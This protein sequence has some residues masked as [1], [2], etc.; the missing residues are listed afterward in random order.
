MF[1]VDDY[2]GLLDLTIGELRERLG[3]PVEGL[4]GKRALHSRAPTLASA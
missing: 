2:D 4:A 3:I 1:Q